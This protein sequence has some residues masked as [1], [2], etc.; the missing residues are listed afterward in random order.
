[1]KTRNA[2]AILALLAS[3]CMTRNENSALVISAVIPPTATAT[4]S[5]ATSS[6][7]CKFDPSQAEYTSLPY[8]PAENRGV[9]AAVVQN[10]LTATSSLNTI[11]RTDSTNFLP[12]QAVVTYEYI[13]ASAGTPPGQT[14]VAASGIEVPG[15]G[16]GTVEVDMFTAPI[17]VPNGTTIR[18]TFHLEGKLLDGSL[19]HTSEREYLFSFCNVAGCGLGGPWAATVGA[20]SRSCM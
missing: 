19:V 8:N 9:V 6:L 3:S 12:H 1:M 17:A 4:G 7:G 5:G 14:I 10:N 11:L 2:L 20:A 15:G 16:K 13:P 18:V